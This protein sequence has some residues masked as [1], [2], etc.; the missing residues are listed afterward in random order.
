M[1]RLGGFGPRAGYASG[2][3]QLGSAP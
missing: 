1:H 3:F 2:A